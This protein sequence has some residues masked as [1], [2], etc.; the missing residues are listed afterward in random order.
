[1]P[2]AWELNSRCSCSQ[3]SRD[4]QPTIK[5]SPDGAPAWLSRLPFCTAGRCRSPPVQGPPGA[6]EASTRLYLQ[7][8]CVLISSH[9]QLLARQEFGETFSTPVWCQWGGCRWSVSTGDSGTPQAGA[10]CQPRCALARVCAGSHVCWLR[11]VL[12][13]VCPAQVCP[14]LGV[15]WLRSVGCC[16]CRYLHKMQSGALKQQSW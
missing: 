15:P 7:G 16:R 4:Q 11:Y 14:G 9:A 1:M 10:V 3:R 5:V 12:T 6:S 2:A 8:P 13:R